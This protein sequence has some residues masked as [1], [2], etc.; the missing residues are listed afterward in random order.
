MNTLVVRD[1]GIARR[2]A[3]T[4]PC[5]TGWRPSAPS[6]SATAARRRA[7]AAALEDAGAEVR[8]VL[9]PRRLAPGGGGRG[10]DRERH[11][12]RGLTPLVSPHAGQTSI[13]LPYRADGEPTALVERGAA[14]GARVIDRPEVLV[15]QG[16]A[17]FERW[18]GAGRLST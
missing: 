7:F 4:R 3:P 10:S 8:V 13:D 1:G 9:A 17:S 12:G 6:C 5:S 15:L 16:A 11:A 18:T 14:A 2:R